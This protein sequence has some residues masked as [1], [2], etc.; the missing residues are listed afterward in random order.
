MNGEK[1]DNSVRPQRGEFR[2][3]MDV[4]IPGVILSRGFLNQGLE[5]GRSRKS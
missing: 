1:R 5:V 3:I 2:T 4:G